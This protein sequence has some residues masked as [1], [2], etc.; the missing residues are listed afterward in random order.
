MKYQY[1][2]AGLAMIPLI[3]TGCG[4]VDMGKSVVETDIGTNVEDVVENVDVDN[5]DVSVT[6]PVT[7]VLVSGHADTGKVS[8]AEDLGFML[9][10]QG[11]DTAV[12]SPESR[13]IALA[14]VSELLSDGDREK[15]EQ[16]LDGRDYL[17]YKGTSS[18]KI[19]NRLWINDAFRFD[20][21]DTKLQDIAYRLDMSDSAKATKEK[22]VFVAENTDNF[23]VSTPSELGPDTVADV[24]NI[25]YFKDK[26]AGGD[27]NLD[28]Y[29]SEFVNADG[30]TVHRH[31][32]HDSGGM[33][34]YSNVAHEYIMDYAD[35]FRFH[36]VVPDEGYGI[37]D[38]DLEPFVDGSAEVF[39][40][41]TFLTMPEFESKSVYT[42]N[43]ADFGLFSFVI[44]KGI[45]GQDG[46]C[47]GD[48]MQVAK[49]RVDHEGTE[50][51]AVTEVMVKT[52]A[53]G[54]QDAYTV[55]C[56]RPFVYYIEDAFNKDIAFMGC[57]T[58]LSDEE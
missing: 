27:K 39:D 21:G 4:V 13:G 54:L 11:G 19:V 20:F 31:M 24:M 44:D 36:V 18:F 53:F 32:M 22:D 45:A 55:V 48:I 46:I 34:R 49:I 47:I 56:D 41:D 14:M 57:V 51:A 52:A 6:E 9:M 10:S 38:I 17:G 8:F 12:F 50:A 29:T 28:P 2:L 16:Y 43:P 58:Y 26:W 25:L 40:G 15:V 3:V 30:E 23:I 42:F 33:V 5:S 35:G 7:E 37:G 1:F